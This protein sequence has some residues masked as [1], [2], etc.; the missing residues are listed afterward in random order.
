MFDTKEES[1]A[2]IKKHHKQDMT[3][4]QEDLSKKVKKK[5][6]DW[7]FKAILIQHL[8]SFKSYSELSKLTGVDIKILKQWIYIS[9][10]FKHEKANEEFQLLKV[11]HKNGLHD[12]T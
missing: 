1:L 11:C 4:H 12:C 9:N 5:K 10:K 8:R 3:W 6:Y 7:Q 2:Y